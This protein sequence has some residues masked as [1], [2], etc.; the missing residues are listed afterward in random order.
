MANENVIIDYFDTC[1][2]HYRRL[3]DLQNSMAMHYGYW[4]ETTKNFPDALKNENILLAQLIQVQ[5]DDI[6]LD[7][8]SGVGGSA[9][10][11]A[12][13]FGCKVIGVTLSEKQVAT[14]RLNAKKHNIAHLV[15]FH[16]KDYLDTGFPDGY[17]SVVWA[18]E[19]ICYCADKKDFLSESSRLLQKNGRI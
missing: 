2:I 4:D 9:I 1:E 17:F 12:K 16:Q 18:V 19:S 3:W 7:A 15:E 14:S 8:G 11:L 13:E 6:I 5:R 10:F